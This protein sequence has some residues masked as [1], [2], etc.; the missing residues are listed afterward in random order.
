M[1]SLNCSQQVPISLRLRHSLTRVRLAVSQVD[2]HNA[3]KSL[4]LER[5]GHIYSCSC[6]QCHNT[7]MHWFR[8]AIEPTMSNVDVWYCF[9]LLLNWLVRGATQ[10]QSDVDT[11]Q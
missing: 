1:M 2:Y 10:Y 9:I 6:Q 8:H 3:I 11:L 4:G 7:N 5:Q